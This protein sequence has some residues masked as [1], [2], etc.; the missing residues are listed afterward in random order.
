MPVFV[1]FLPQ[2]RVVVSR[3]SIFNW[4]VFPETAELSVVPQADTLHCIIVKSMIKENLIVKML[5]NVNFKNIIVKIL[6]I[7]IFIYYY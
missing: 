1:V 5:I 7:N 2:F 3:N 6:D 4:R